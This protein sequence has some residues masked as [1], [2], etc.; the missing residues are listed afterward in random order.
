ME[1]GGYLVLAFHADN[2]GAWLMHCHIGF[3]A[4]EG[5]ALQILE[6]KNEIPSLL[7]Q[8]VLHKTCNAWK[9]FGRHNSYGIQEVV[10]DGPYDSGI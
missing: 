7:D 4:A 6:R 10:Y 5:F 2:P 9:R 8:D 1:G 3:H